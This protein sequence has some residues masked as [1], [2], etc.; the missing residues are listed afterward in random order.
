MRGD[1]H[2]NSVELAFSVWKRG[3]TGSFHQVSIKHLQRY[4]HEFGY[5]F[6]RRETKDLFEQTIGRMVDV[7]KMPY[8]KLVEQQEG[9][10]FRAPR[11]EDF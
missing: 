5:R 6:N 2:T 3:I 9:H 10:A 4:L 1:I 11:A 7:K 8:S